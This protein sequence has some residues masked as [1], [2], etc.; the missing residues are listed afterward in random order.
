[1][2][3]KSAIVVLSFGSVLLA[4]CNCKQQQQ[5]AC[6]ERWSEA[7]ANT[8]YAGQGWPVGVNYV[9]STAINQIEMWQAETFDPQT[10]DKEMGWME[11]LGFN[12][13]RVFL[14]DL[15]WQVDPDGLK[16]RLSR[17][18]EICER[19]RLKV[20]VTFFTNGGK[21]DQPEAKMGKQPEPIQGVHN[22]GWLQTPKAEVVNDS[23]QWK[24]LENYVKDILT[25]F[26]DDSRILLWCLYNEPQN[27]NR[28]A[29]AMGLLRAA[30]RWARSV[31]PSQPLSSPLWGI[32]ARD[33]ALDIVA[34]LCEN[35]DVM[36]FHCYKDAETMEAFIKMLKRFNRP[37]ICQEYM[38]RPESLFEDILPI[39]KRENVG[40]ISWGLVKG[41]CNF[42]VH[43]T[44]KAGEPEPEI[45]FHDILHVDG[46]P[47]DPAEIELIKQITKQE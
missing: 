3:I 7:K 38:G 43:W 47:Y 23:T 20:I 1:M 36:T 21:P 17:F 29:E 12:T 42:H 35:C 19:H 37:M 9:T 24:P 14:Y 16:A 28:G 5:T 22:S 25:T 26:K 31:N 41:K 46:T 34:F 11:D 13:V 27:T 44:H 39:L 30:F 45:W 40:A 4:A 33:T 15:V 18:L 8:W 6:N 32:P 2:N 10:I